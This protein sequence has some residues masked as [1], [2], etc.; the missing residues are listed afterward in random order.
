MTTVLQ[1]IQI[2][3]Y[4]SLKVRLYK[5]LIEDCKFVGNCDIQI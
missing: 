1:E 3:R 2:K 4:S 5:E